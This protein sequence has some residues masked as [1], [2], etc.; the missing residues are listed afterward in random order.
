MVHHTSNI[1]HI[2][3]LVIF[4]LLTRTMNFYGRRD[5]SDDGIR[6]LYVSR[7][8]IL[9]IF[10]NF[11]FLSQYLACLPACLDFVTP[12]TYILNFS[13][14]FLGEVRDISDNC[15]SLV[16]PIVLDTGVTTHRIIARR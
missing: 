11:W 12:F 15:K 4:L 1:L 16:T 5:V 7:V 8:K 2:W 3:W 13:I 9:V 6:R 10:R 14:C